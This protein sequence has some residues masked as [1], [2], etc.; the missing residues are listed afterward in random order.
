[1]SRV[2][3]TLVLLASTVCSFAKTKEHTV[4]ANYIYYAPTNVTIEQAQMTALERAKIEAIANKFGTRISQTNTTAITNANGE[5]S[6][7]FISLSSSEVNGEWIET[8]G[9]PKF[10]LSYSNGILVV[11]VKVK[12][13]IRELEQNTADIEVQVL[14]N[15]IEDKYESDK[16]AS[17]DDLFI[18]VT[19]AEVGYVAI[20]LEDFSGR[21][22][23]LLPY[24]RQPDQSL[25]IES[26]KRYVFFHKQSV[27]PQERR[28]V[29]EYVMTADSQHEINNI[30]FIF[31]PSPF[32]T[33]IA[34]SEI[35]NELRQFSVNEYRTWEA[36][37]R[38]KHPQSV[39]KH[40]QIVVS[41]KK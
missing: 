17:S 26:G 15:G 3:I 24:R 7:Q 4:E 35:E 8:I 22:Y 27:P 28:M 29:D 16:F 41:P 34:D 14:R 1:M 40:F 5:S 6:T 19:S 30:H 23:R 9:T 25:G 31:S 10:E 39:V 21:V 37:L 18:S 13:K 20:F 33:R 2:F 12:G 38:R 36:E 32:L 11:S